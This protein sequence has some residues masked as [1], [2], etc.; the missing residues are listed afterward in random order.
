MTSAVLKP[1]SFEEFL[2]YDAPDDRSYELVEGELVPMTM[3]NNA[4]ESVAHFLYETFSLTIR[5]AKLAYVV[6]LRYPVRV[7][8]KQGVGTGRLPD[9]V[10]LDKAAY[11]ASNQQAAGS[12]EPPPLVVEVVSNNWKDDYATKLEEYERTGIPEYWTVDYAAIAPREYNGWPKR[13]TVSVSWW[14][15]GVYETRRFRG[16][17]RIVSPTFPNLE[18]TVNAVV[19]SIEL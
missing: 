13:P 12:F 5:Q 19:E 17:E 2:R 10:V 7:D 9:V 18:L 16:D 11:L 1:L 15:E 6:R 8:G 14:V 3:P 4:H